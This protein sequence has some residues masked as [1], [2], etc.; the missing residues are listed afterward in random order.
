MFKF[1]HHAVGLAAS[2]TS[3]AAQSGQPTV[4]RFDSDSVRVSVDNCCTR[5]L[6]NNVHHF[7]D[8]VMLPV[9]KCRGLGDKKGEGRIIQGPGTLVF[10]I[11]DDKG[12]WHVIKLGNSLLLLRLMT[13]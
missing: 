5:S 4:T 12:G 6:S 8:L 7:E 3:M 9:G 1:F 10:T 2:S 11:Q 13:R